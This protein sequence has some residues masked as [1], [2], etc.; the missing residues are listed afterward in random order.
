MP[1]ASPFFT[2]VVTGNRA[3]ETR[4]YGGTAKQADGQARELWLDEGSCAEGMLSMRRV[5]TPG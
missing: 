3:C 1:P 2:L 4:L 5:V